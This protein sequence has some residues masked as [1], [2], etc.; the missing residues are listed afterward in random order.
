MGSGSGEKTLIRADWSEEARISV[1]ACKAWLFRF[2]AKT[3]RLSGLD[4]LVCMA[5]G[6]KVRQQSGF[7]SSCVKPESFQ[8]NQ[9]IDSVCLNNLSVCAQYL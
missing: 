9:H 6:W 4:F 5:P 8:W 7:V 3:Q 1:F 2:Q